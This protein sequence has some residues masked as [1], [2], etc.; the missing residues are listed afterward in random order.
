MICVIADDLAGAAELGGVALRHGYS[1]EVQLAFDAGSSAE[2]ICVNTDSRSCAA[3]E[4]ARRA[5]Q[6]AMDCREAGITGVFKK[7]DSVLRGWVVSEL[8]AMLPALGR[9]R[10]LL[11]PANPGRGRVIREGQYWI[12][13]RPLHETDFA[14]DPE[15]P[16]RSPAVLAL[17]GAS[18]TGPVHVLP[19]GSSLPPRGILV[20]EASCPADLDAWA[21]RL[22]A[23]TLPAGAAEFFAAFLAGAGNRERGDE[24]V[25]M[26]G[27]VQEH[28]LFVC[29]STSSASRAF[30]RRAEAGGV[31]VQRM[32]AGLLDPDPPRESLV[33]EWAAATVRALQAHP[34]AVVA[35]DRPLQPEPGMPRRLSEAL[36]AAVRQ[37][38][39][40]QEVEGLLVE[41]GATAMALM[42]ALGW[43]R[44]GVERELAPGVV[45]LRPAG[46]AGP[47]VVVK[48][49]SYAW[50][51]EVSGVER[52]G[53]DLSQISRGVSR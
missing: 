47:L 50:P 45:G 42:Q 48:P 3:H 14:R 28:V 15:H 49:G 27:R 18:G 9:E 44:L 2:V 1:A 12:D 6:I 36:A 11:V 16:V 10:A 37:V 23:A 46:R 32:P 7:V 13:G 5:A 30:L 26:L 35:I 17:L 41:G 34:R 21:G 43:A 40:Q 31:P 22:D 33:A 19:A 29:G 39:E 24:P 4:A 8:S 51:E 25:A 38:L 52:Q 20:G 53:A